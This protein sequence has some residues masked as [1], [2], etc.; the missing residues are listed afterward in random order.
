[1]NPVEC[2]CCRGLGKVT[3]VDIEFGCYIDVKNSSDFPYLTCSPDYCNVNYNQD[4]CPY[5]R[6]LPIVSIS[7]EALYNESL[8]NRSYEVSKPY[9]L[10]TRMIDTNKP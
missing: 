10:I 5:W 7:D 3:D 9:N 2:P 8:S 1:M 6:P 4:T